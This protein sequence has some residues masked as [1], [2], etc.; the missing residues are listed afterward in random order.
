MKKLKLLVVTFIF[1]S[2]SPKD[3]MIE[4][5]LAFKT[6]EIGNYYNLD[7]NGVD[8][9]EKVLD[10]IR[11]IKNPTA[12]DMF[13]LQ[14]FDA[15][16]KHNVI[17]SPYIRLKTKDSII[18]VYLKENDFEKLK[19]YNSN[20]LILKNKKITLKM[21]SEIRGDNLYYCKELIN[22]KEVDGRTYTSK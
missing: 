5:D 1:I 7:Q 14:Y 15:L 20:D 12:N 2:C 13:I 19:N 22:V 9:W 18:I 4:G 6:V 8:D 11:Q 10:G 21:N 16:K 17:K 3:K